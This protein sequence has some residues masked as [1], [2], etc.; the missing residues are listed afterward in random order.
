MNIT[1]INWLDISEKLKITQKDLDLQ[2]EVKS[3]GSTARI[4]KLEDLVPNCIEVFWDKLYQVLASIEPIKIDDQYSPKSTLLAIPDIINTPY[5]DITKDNLKGILV[6]INDIPRSKTLPGRAGDH[7][8]WS[9]L[10]PLWLAAYKHYKNIPYSAWI[11]DTMISHFVGPG[12]YN[13]IMTVPED[14]RLNIEN[15]AELR[16]AALSFAK[17][18][19]PITSPVRKGFQ[20]T[21][22][23]RVPLNSKVGAMI[24]QIWLANVQLRHPDMILDPFDWDKI[25]EAFDHVEPNIVANPNMQP[26]KKKYIVEEL[27]F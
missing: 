17:G 9:Q 11:K 22:D 2:N 26:K 6:V 4:Y 13:D 16:K 14:F 10:V 5:G 20:M 18:V 3:T 25:P 21:K 8:Q 19:S 7:P 12:L 24:L 1:K 27:P 23:W 15:L